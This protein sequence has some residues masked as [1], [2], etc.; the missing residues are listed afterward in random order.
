MPESLET[1][2]TATWFRS[3]SYPY[4]PYNIHSRSRLLTEVSSEKVMSCHAPIRCHTRWPYF[5]T[6]IM[7]CYRPGSKNT[8]LTSCHTLIPTQTK[9][10]NP[11]YLPPSSW[12][13]LSQRLIMKLPKPFSIT[14]LTPVLLV[15][16]VPMTLWVTNYLDQH[17]NWYQP[18]YFLFLLPNLRYPMLHQ[19]EN[20]C[21]SDHRLYHRPPR[22]RS[23]VNHESHQ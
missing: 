19:L 15:T 12:M 18:I 22:G 14:F 13:H 7:L 11:P 23:M 1:P 2:L 6:R 10:K 17:G 20:S 4:N 21:H 3:S 8:K 9:A 5:L 16:L